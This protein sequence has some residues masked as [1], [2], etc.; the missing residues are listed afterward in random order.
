V[1]YDV[2]RGTLSALRSQGLDLA[3]SCADGDLMGPVYDDTSP[4]PP[5]RD[6]YF[7]LVR[8]RNSCA[9]PGFGRAAIDDLACSP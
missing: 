6:G 5:A 1:R 2:A 9:S 8:S 3:T 4:P 7:Y